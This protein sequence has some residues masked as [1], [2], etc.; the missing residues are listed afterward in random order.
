[1]GPAAAERVV[2]SWTLPNG[3][4]IDL[5]IGWYHKEMEYP[6]SFRASRGGRASHSSTPWKAVRNLLRF[7][8]VKIQ[9][10]WEEE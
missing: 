3:I 9:P 10:I 5:L 7:E 4:K 2:R 1:M 8:K 6:I